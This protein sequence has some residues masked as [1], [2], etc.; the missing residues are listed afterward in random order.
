MAMCEEALFLFGPGKDRHDPMGGLD[1][2]TGDVLRKTGTPGTVLA[3]SVQQ[4]TAVGAVGQVARATAG[5]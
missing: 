1:W 5:G 2:E 3:V 4:A